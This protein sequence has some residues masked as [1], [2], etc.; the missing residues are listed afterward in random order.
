MENMFRLQLPKT[1]GGTEEVQTRQ[2]LLLIGANGA[3]KTRL[4]TWIESD[5]PQKEKVHRISA[6]KSLS[7]PDNTTPKSIDMAEKELLY[8]HA[9]AQDGN[10]WTYKQGYRWGR[11]P[12][13][14]LLNDYERLMVYLFS[15]HT[16]ESAKYLS[17]SKASADKVEPPIT[18]LDLVKQVWEKVLPHRE[19]ILGGLRI[20]TCVKGDKDKAYSASEMSDGERVIFYLIGQCLAAPKDGIIIIDEPELHLHK[21]VQA[22]LWREIEGL[23]PDCLFVYM[24]HDVDFAASLHE[25]KKIWLKSFDGSNWSWEIVNEIEGLPESLLIEV[26]GSRKPVAFVEGENGSYDTSLY[27]AVLSDYLVVPSGSCSQVIQLVKALKASEQLHHLDVFGIIDRDRRVD[28][29]ITSLQA[30]GIYTLEVAEV[31]NLFC[32]PEIIKVVSTRLARDP[33]ADCQSSAEFVLNKINSELDN[34]VSL[35]VASEIKFRLNCFDEKSKGKDALHDALSSL[36]ESINVDGL[37]NESEA[38]F[39]QAV[40]E[41][42]YLLALRIYNRKSLARQ[43]SNHLGLAHGELA[44]FVVRLANSENRLEIK[45]ALKGYFGAFGEKIA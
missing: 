44:E 31:E 43:L 39:N 7:M 33:D 18:K 41:N 28:L 8:G 37:Y 20:Q 14:F 38:L 24:T 35:R 23:R 26:L 17:A 27:R 29:E 3:G 45:N 13:T 22:P 2:S 1:G 4:G 16:E 25:S 21:S 6:Q 42:D 30:N 36:Y 34:Q 12:S 40:N 9:D 15:D 10:F 32:V 11:K 19:L 5:S